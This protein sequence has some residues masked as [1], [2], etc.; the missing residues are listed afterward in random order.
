M[1]ESLFSYFLSSDSILSFSYKATFCKHLQSDMISI[2][3]NR[4]SKYSL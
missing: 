4:L 1:F 2:N 3:L